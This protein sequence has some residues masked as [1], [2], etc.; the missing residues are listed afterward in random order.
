MMSDQL[1]DSSKCSN[2]MAEK[3]I[4]TAITNAAKEA[5]TQ[6][7]IINELMGKGEQ[8]VDD[9]G[10]T[11]DSLGRELSRKR[12]HLESMAKAINEH[13]QAHRD[14]SVNQWNELRDQ[15]LILGKELGE[16]TIM[17]FGRTMSGKSTTFEAFIQG[18][19]SRIGNGVPDFTKD[20][21]PEYWNGLRLVDTPGLDGFD[22]S[23]R[24]A[25][26]KWVDRSDIIAMVISDDHIE[27]VLLERMA[28]I[29]RHN[30]PLIILLNVKC[31]NIDRLVDYPELVFRP[32]EIE[33]HIK[34]IRGYLGEK[35]RESHTPLN[36]DAVPIF[37]FC[38]EA[39]FLARSKG[40]NSDRV[41]ALNSASRFTAITEH[42]ISLVRTRAII[43]RVKAAYDAF[44]IRLQQIEDDLRIRLG[45]IQV[46]AMTLSQK[47]SEACKMVTR[48]KENA[49]NRFDAELKTHFNAVED[50]LEAFV[51]SVAAGNEDDPEKALNKIMGWKYVKLKLSDFRK[52][53]AEDVKKQVAQFEKDL[54]FDFEITLEDITN[55]WQYNGTAFH[56]GWAQLK[57]KAGKFGKIASPVV[58]GLAT[59]AVANFWNP[60]GWLAGL[61]AAAVA[62]A[63]GIGATVLTVKGSDLLERSG[64]DTLKQEK[65]ELKKDLMKN[66]HEK[67]D[68]I[69]QENLAW[70]EKTIDQAQNTILESIKLM[71]RRSEEFRQAARKTLRELV[72]LRNQ[73]AFAQMRA[74]LPLSY[75][76]SILAKFDVLHVVRR[77]GY[78]MKILVRSRNEHPIGGLL[79]G[80]AG[81]NLDRLVSNIG[82]EPIDIID[83]S[84]NIWT[85]QNLQYAIRP[86][87][88]TE[89][90]IP[91]GEISGSN[92]S[93]VH[94]TFDEK[95]RSRFFGPHRW[96][97]Q[98][99]RDITNLEFRIK[100]Q[101]DQ[102]EEGAF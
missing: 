10:G 7:N 70:A 89:V 6:F 17:F 91:S 9:F 55:N 22:E 38:A 82:A 94:L 59:W 99:F 13:L 4:S 84:N 47:E 52:T 2:H 98:L 50:E 42:V 46:E 53:T 11:I 45:Q 33:G 26:E 87:Y 66:I 56:F 14:M 83:F 96:N 12:G 34:R 100:Y 74:L 18:D 58:G 51:D 5:Y 19:G 37:P 81:A 69:R 68:S 93:V 31:G 79:V 32:E 21:S 16:F 1:M 27:P 90:K 72:L 60:S 76:K 64:K 97:M 86:A 24:N 36:P 85:I 75:P 43:I 25:A 63:A 15:M 8:I 49:M 28:K 62:V 101:E 39:A 71:T 88:A 80:H 41:L 102:H 92:S 61:A 78:R 3:D 35:F 65:A 73:I 23:V 20:V 57:K 95:N 54:K 29:I 40:E 30:K 67:Y 48:L 77:V 44:M